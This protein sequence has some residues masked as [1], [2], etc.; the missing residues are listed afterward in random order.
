[1][2][3]RSILLGTLEAAV[4]LFGLGGVLLFIWIMALAMGIDA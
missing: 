2:T 3:A 4:F 1:M